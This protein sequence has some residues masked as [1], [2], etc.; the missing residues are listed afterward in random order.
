MNI[1]SYISSRISA[2]GSGKRSIARPIVRIAVGGI[3]LGIAVMIITMA[4]VT[5][6][7]NEIKNKVIG[8]GSHIS[9]TRFTNNVSYEP[10]PIAEKQSFLNELKLNPAIKHI[11]VF[12]TKNGIIKTTTDNEGVVI[13]GVDNTYDWTFMQSS[14]IDGKVI[15]FNDSSASRDMLISKSIADRL[16]VKT[17]DKLLI[18]FINRRAMNDS[19][20]YIKYEQRVRDFRVSGI[21]ETGFEELDN[22]TVFADIK[23]IKKLNYWSNDQVGGFEIEL[24][25]ID[26][27][28]QLTE[29]VNDVIGYEYQA[30]S[31]KQSNEGIFSWLSLMDSNAIIIITLMIAVAAINMISALLILIL[32]RTNMIGLLKAL[33]MSNGSVRRIFMNQAIRLI[34]K[35]LIYGNIIGIA[36]C[37][38]QLKFHWVKLDKRVYYLDAVPVNFDL[39]HVVILNLG[40]IAV[41]FLMMLL[42][43][44]VITKITPVKALRFR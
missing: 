10:E 32:E 34:A 18:Y 9:I 36:L 7:Q 44:L 6:F 5:G 27:I 4:I 25:S 43:T 39:L 40:T 15:A 37:L 30:Q 42:P 21:Y 35:G 13:K 3:A 16:N 14:L 2:S 23:Q 28:D 31:I 11:Q 17:G 24:K 20:E 33:G 12:A 41:C 29:E 19:D 8:F 22:K 26:K 38:L 1:H